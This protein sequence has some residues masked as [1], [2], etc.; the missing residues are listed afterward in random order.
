[1]VAST[2]CEDVQDL[3]VS[4]V[5]VHDAAGMLAKPDVAS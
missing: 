2:Q 1:V 5:A 4:H 3:D